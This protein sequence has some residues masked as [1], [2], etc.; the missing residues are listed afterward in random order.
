MLELNTKLKMSCNLLCHQAENEQVTFV[1]CLKTEYFSMV[2]MT[3]NIIPLPFCPYQYVDMNIMLTALL[4]VGTTCSNNTNKHNDF[5]L[6][7]NFFT[8]II[9]VY[10]KEWD[11]CLGFK[12][13]CCD[14]VFVFIPCAG[15]RGLHT[16][17]SSYHLIFYVSLN[18]G[19]RCL[20]LILW[21]QMSDENVA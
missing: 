2:K 8:F 9:M 19:A 15:S 21:P 4:C 18:L 1:R 12:R 14:I 16:I 10:I 7:F 11:T 6:L 17:L 20:Q 13:L 5:F 3:V